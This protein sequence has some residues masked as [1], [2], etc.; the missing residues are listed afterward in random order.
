MDSPTYMPLGNPNASVAVAAEL[1]PGQP[2][3]LPR[4]VPQPRLLDSFEDGT[5]QTANRPRRV[6]LNPPDTGNDPEQT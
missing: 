5:D 3:A 4:F 6:F 1:V 2:S